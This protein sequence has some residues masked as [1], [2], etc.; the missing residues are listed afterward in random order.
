[1]TA[2]PR[3]MR[4][5]AR[6]P[7]SAIVAPTLAIASGVA[8]SRSWPIAAA[9]TARL[10]RSPLGG[11]IRAT[12]AAGMRGVSLN[13]KRSAAATRRLAPSFAPIGAKTELHETTNALTS[14]PPHDSLLAL[15]SRTPESVAAVRTGYV[16]VG[17]AMPFWSAAESVMILNVDPG[18][19]GPETARPASARTDPSRGRRSATPP[20][21]LPSACWAARCRPGLIVAWTAC[22]RRTL[23]RR[24][25]RWP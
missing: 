21:R 15:R 3:V 4:G 22:P 12:F 19:C 17:L 7:F 20:S 23:T 6:T 8:R 14:V 13:P 18:G 25:R 5:F 1:M 16:L 24:I 9:P 2:S 10:S 11:E